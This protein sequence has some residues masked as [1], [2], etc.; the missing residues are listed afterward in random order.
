MEFQRRYQSEI[1][2]KAMYARLFRFGIFRAT[3]YEEELFHNNPLPGV[4]W[5]GHLS[6]RRAAQNIDANKAD[7]QPGE[8]ETSVVSQDIRCV[9]QTSL[10]A[11]MFS[12]LN[13]SAQE[14]WRCLDQDGMWQIEW[15]SNG[16]KQWNTAAHSIIRWQCCK[17]KLSV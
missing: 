2:T 16:T 8:D 4:R 14:L 15:R 9:I 7:E 10:K 1:R 6:N 5:Q 17:D 12:T 3:N 11:Q 13:C